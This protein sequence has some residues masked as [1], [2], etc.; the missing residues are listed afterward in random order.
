[1]PVPGPASSTPSSAPSSHDNQ[2]LDALRRRI[3]ALE[4]FS[5]G[6]GAPAPDDAVSLG[7]AAL[8]GHLPWGGLPRGALHEVVS[9]AANN[10]YGGV[11]AAAGFTAAV[12]GR[13]ARADGRALVWCRRPAQGFRP[14]LYGAGLARFGLDPAHLILV[15]P[16][17]NQAVLWC[18]EECLR[19][20]AVAAVLG[21]VDQA[22]TRAQRRLHLAAEDS[23]IP[24]LLLLGGRAASLPGPAVTRWRVSGAPGRSGAASWRVELMKC[25]GGGRPGEWTLEWRET[26]DGEDGRD[27]DDGTGYGNRNDDD[28]R[29]PTQPAG[30]FRLAPPFLHRPAAAAPQAAGW[31][32]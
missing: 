18:M 22:N 19:S 24:A 3:A 13:L 31:A 21:E 2:D 32:G 10:G 15:Q 8:D 5:G 23:G 6:G 11:A 29:H 4:R 12:L 1:M 14:G 9:G 17:D 25:R 7:L 20:G 27:G 30:G 26:D 28:A 16:P